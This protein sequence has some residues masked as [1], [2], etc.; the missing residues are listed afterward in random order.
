[1]NGRRSE[2]YVIDRRNSGVVIS[3]SASPITPDSEQEPM[4]SDGG[5]SKVNN[6]GNE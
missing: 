2:F 4:K 1:M 3:A 5:K 6:L